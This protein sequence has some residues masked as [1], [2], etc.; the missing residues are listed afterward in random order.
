MVDNDV[1][2]EQLLSDLP[3]IE[4]FAVF[5]R[6]TPEFEGPFASEEGRRLLTEHLL[7]LFEIQRGGALLASGPLDLNVERIEGMC[8]LRASSRVEAEKMAYDEPYQRAG[9]RINTV[10]SWQL[11]EGLL[12]Q[13]TQALLGTG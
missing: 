10:Q 13:P 5:M 8:I 11:N 2:L 4:L 7:Y 1:N 12:V 6:P 3:N 9:W